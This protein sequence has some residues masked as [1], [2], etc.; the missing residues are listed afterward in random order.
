MSLFKRFSKSIV[1]SALFLLPTTFNISAQGFGGGLTNNN[2]PPGFGGGP[3][4]FPPPPFPTPTPVPVV[5]KDLYVGS[6]SSGQTT[7]FD[8]GKISIVTAI[9]AIYLQIQIIG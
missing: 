5:L 9:L 3:F 8:A 4:P 2:N 6:N 7:N 1:L